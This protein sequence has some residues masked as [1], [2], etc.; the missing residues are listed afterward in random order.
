VHC[1]REELR[2]AR[3]IE[4]QEPEEEPKPQIECPECGCRFS[5]GRDRPT[6]VAA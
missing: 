4:A 1:L 3:R 6:P 5:K 2:R